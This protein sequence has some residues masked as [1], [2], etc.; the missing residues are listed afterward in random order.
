MN[1]TTQVSK[2]GQGDGQGEAR[3]RNRGWFTK[4]DPRIRPLQE[5]ARESQ[6]SEAARAAAGPVQVEAVGSEDVSL[7][8]TMRQVFNQPKERDRGQPQRECRAWL[9]S[10]RKG[11]MSKL[12]DLEKALTKGQGAATAPDRRDEGT[13]RVLAL[14]GEGMGADEE[15]RAEEDAR[16]AARLG[17]AALGAAEQ[18]ELKGL[19]W[20]ERQLY[21]RVTARERGEPQ[22]AA[23]AVLRRLF[24]DFWKGQRSRGVELA[25]HPNPGTTIASMRHEIE[26]TR[27]RV[28]QLRQKLVRW[29]DEDEDPPTLDDC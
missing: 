25:V 21:E 24:D 17:A 2:T 20:Q 1:T 28:E 14:L 27:G 18:A 15:R 11:F 29:D 10:D 6:P 26:A 4:R 13:E 9:K 16:L 19:L 3:P 5:K 12:A 22:S 23:D 8:T 7:Y